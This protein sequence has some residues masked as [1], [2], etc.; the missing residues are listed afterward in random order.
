MKKLFLISAV[1]LLMGLVACSGNKDNSTS[2]SSESSESVQSVEEIKDGNTFDAKS[3][4]ISYPKDWK[5]TFSTD[6]ILNVKSADKTMTF[7]INYD[8]EGPTADQLKEKADFAKLVNTDLYKE[9][10]EPKIIADNFITLRRVTNEGEVELSYTKV[11]EG[12]KCIMGSMK[13]PADKE[14][15]AEKILMSIIN[16]VKLK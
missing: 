6:D 2:D 4:T 11:F 15:E 8:A 5:K 12:T 1:A 14:A 10:D 16:S 9:V 3:Y 13:S 7:S